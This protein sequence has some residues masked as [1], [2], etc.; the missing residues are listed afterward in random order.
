M[1][2]HKLIGTLI[3][4]TLLVIGTGK[5]KIYADENSIDIPAG[6]IFYGNSIINSVLAIEQTTNQHTGMVPLRVAQAQWY[7]QKKYT[8]TTE[9]TTKIYQYGIYEIGIYTRALNTNEGQGYES[10]SNYDTYNLGIDM[11]T[12]LISY[13]PP[14]NTNI[15]YYAMSDALSGRIYINIENKDKY[16]PQGIEVMI[17]EIITYK[18][19]TTTTEI[20]SP[21][22]N[23]IGPRG[24]TN[25]E[26]LYAENGETVYLNQKQYEAIIE[27]LGGGSGSGSGTGGLTQEQYEELLETINE[28]TTV[29]SIDGKIDEIIDLLGQSLDSTT[30]DQIADQAEN[31]QQTTAEAIQQEQEYS[32][33]M[34]DQ[35]DD[36]NVNDYTGIL[37]N[38]KFISTMNWIR[39]VHLQTVENTEIGG[40][41]TLVLIIGLAVYLIGR[42]AG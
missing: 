28:A 30:Q 23:Y 10:L 37:S 41:V 5:H 20:Y 33:N 4:S 17:P 39:Q 13:S 7:I 1:K 14:G 16:Y 2:I 19:G 11:D 32:E 36:I 22:Q 31:V 6:T 25:Y 35:L 38:G 24:N 40:V 9:D 12:I 21:N 15:N 8:Y 3:L 34:Q 42:R 29:V 26:L 18:N 27:A